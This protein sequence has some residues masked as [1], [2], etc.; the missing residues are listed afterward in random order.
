MCGDETQKVQV[1]ASLNVEHFHPSIPCSGLDT[2]VRSTS[3]SSSPRHTHTHTHAPQ[4]RSGSR[5]GIIIPNK[6]GV[7]QQPANNLHEAS[8]QQRERERE[9]KSC[10]GQQACHKLY[11]TLFFC[12]LSYPD[13]NPPRSRVWW[14][15]WWWLE[16][17]LVRERFSM[18]A[19]KIGFS[20][21][22]DSPRV[23]YEDRRDIG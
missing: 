15:R 13:P 4:H 2:Q 6:L 9:R 22:A 19:L 16:D 12:P 8:K 3:S 14:C 18:G 17:W 23:L 1:V 21:R 20:G 11:D 5:G 10:V 7:S